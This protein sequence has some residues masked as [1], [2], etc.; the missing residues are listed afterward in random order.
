MGTDYTDYQ[1]LLLSTPSDVGW[2]VLWHI[3]PCRL[4]KAKSCLFTLDVYDLYTK[5]LG[6]NIFKR[7]RTHLFANS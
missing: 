5:E 6:G 3:K 2:W 4:F 7:A 1:E